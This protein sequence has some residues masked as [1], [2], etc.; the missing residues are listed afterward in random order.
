VRYL[1][2]DLGDKRTGVA[3][4]DDQ[5]GIVSPIEVVEIDRRRL[6]EDGYTEALR[7]LVAHHLGERERAQG[8]I[9]LGL[10]C[11]MDGTEGLP[12]VKA[13]AIALKLGEIAARPVHLVDE[14]LTTAEAD[15]SL[16]RSGLTRGEKK[17]RRDALAA[18]AILRDFLASRAPRRDTDSDG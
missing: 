4:G 16:A 5:T 9:V 10:P 3:M 11:N 2:L 7:R 14:R 1:G 13:R 18:A 6:G 17:E 15:W 12:A 8:E